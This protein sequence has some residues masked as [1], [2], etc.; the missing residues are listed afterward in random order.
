MDRI[1]RTSERLDAALEAVAAAFPQ[2]G[3]LEAGGDAFRAVGSVALDL[4]PPGARVLDMGA[5]RCAKACVLAALGFHVTAYDDLL[6][7]HLT[8]DDRRDVRELCDRFGVKLHVSDY[9]EPRPFVAESFEMV[10]LHDVLEHLHDSP[11]ILLN[12]LIGYLVT[13]GALFVTVPNAANLRK[14]IDLLRGRTNLPRFDH[15]FW[16]PN[17]WRGHVREYVRDDLE[18]LTANLGLELV[19]L[20][21]GHHMIAKVPARLRAPYRA[22]T[23]VVPAW[24]DTWGLV[25]RKPKDWHPA[26]E[27]PPDFDIRFGR[28][29]CWDA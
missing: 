26:T 28:L 22:V 17:P 10:M 29:G 19:Q 7:P 3:Y 13:G 18:R 5:G 9:A 14:R 24:R 15:Y 16:H 25:A 1:A 20:E 12:E 2:A 21:S 4:L 11:R 27:P 6:D 23:R 8:D